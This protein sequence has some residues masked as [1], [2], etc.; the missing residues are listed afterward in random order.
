M[1]WYD[2]TGGIV[3]FRYNNV[4]YHYVKN[5]QS[6]IVG[7]LNGSHDVI[8]RYDYGSW[9]KLIRIKDGSGN[10]VTNSA[11]HIGHINP[12]RYRSYYFDYETEWYYLKSRYY[13]PV[14]GRFINADGFVQT[15]TGSLNSTNIFAYCENNPVNSLDLPGNYYTFP[16]YLTDWE[17]WKKEDDEDPPFR[18]Y[19]PH[20]KITPSQWENT[21]KSVLVIQ[22]KEMN[23]EDQTETSR[24]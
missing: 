14:S 12:V 10:N 22:K 7:I 6:D 1:Y 8:A 4:H 11:T 15:P 2:Q 9:G 23:G 18:V 13:D 16:D 24:K 5:L 3:G 19:A 17:S 20:R 21:L